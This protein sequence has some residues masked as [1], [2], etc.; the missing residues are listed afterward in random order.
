M[1]WLP[2]LVVACAAVC[3]FVCGCATT[4]TPATCKQMDHDSDGAITTSDV[5]H[6][7]MCVSAGT[8]CQPGDDVDGDGKL[9]ESDTQ[10]IADR[11]G[12]SCI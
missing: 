7:A 5:A 8:D 3:I 6:T 11:V 12:E 1:K 9:T 4:N 10:Q 2:L